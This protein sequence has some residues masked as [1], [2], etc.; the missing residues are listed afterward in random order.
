MIAVRL[1]SEQKERLEQLASQRNQT[2]SDVIRSWIDGD[3][4]MNG[5][6][7]DLMKQIEAEAKRRGI[8]ARQLITMLLSAGFGRLRKTGSP[9][10]F[11]LD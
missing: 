3:S 5:I 11:V 2:V 7:P 9:N 6:S 10:V 1:T 4:G 8:P